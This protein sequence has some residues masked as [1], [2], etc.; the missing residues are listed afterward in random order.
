MTDDRRHTGTGSRVG[1]PDGA[2]VAS[3]LAAA[4]SARALGAKPPS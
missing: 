1:A 4:A 2:V 3:V